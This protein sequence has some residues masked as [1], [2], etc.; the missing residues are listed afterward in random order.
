MSKQ[1]LDSSELVVRLAPDR[2]LHLVALGRQRFDCRNGLP[3]VCNGRRRRRIR[4]MVY[5]IDEVQITKRGSSWDGVRFGLWKPSNRGRHVWLWRERSDLLL[6]LT[7]TLM[8]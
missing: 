3:H 4:L 1:V 5:R 2:E 6:D 8:P 7:P